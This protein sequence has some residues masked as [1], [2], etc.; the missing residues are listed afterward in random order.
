M[1][2]SFISRFLLVGGIFAAAL[3]SCGSSGT[4]PGDTNVES[5]AAK[6]QINE[7]T[8]ES[9]D[10][11]GRMHTVPDA[12]TNGTASDTSKVTTG[13]QVYDATQDRR[14]ENL[15]GKAGPQ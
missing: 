14:D 5:A 15:D 2:I 8:S 1:K 12:A 9:N 10:P 13:E 3:T 4:N 7:N 6:E 11:D